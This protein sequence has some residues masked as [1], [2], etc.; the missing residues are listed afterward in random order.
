M[1]LIEILCIVFVYGSSIEKKTS[2][3]ISKLGKSF[4]NSDTLKRVKDKFKRC[5]K[6]ENNI[7]ISDLFDRDTLFI[8]QS[9]IESNHL[10]EF[11]DYIYNYNPKHH[12][13]PPLHQ[14][15]RCILLMDVA[16]KIINDEKYNKSVILDEVLDVVKKFAH[17]HLKILKIEDVEIPSFHRIDK[18]FDASDPYNY[19]YKV[20]KWFM[21][22][23][24]IKN[25]Y[26]IFENEN[27]S[28]KWIEVLELESMQ[29]LGLHY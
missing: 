9:H 16:I 14:G 29:L 28:F 1:F 22:M 4:R 26:L 25:M 8:K 3:M 18:N 20:Y 7:N 27:G 19:E 13:I 5:Q 12:A 15:M 6:K 23:Y 24:N 10:E 2:N 17:L 21:Q 11:F